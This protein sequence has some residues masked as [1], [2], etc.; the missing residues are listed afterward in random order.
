[1]LNEIANGDQPALTSMSEEEEEEEEGAAY[2]RPPPNQKY[3]QKRSS[4][5]TLMMTPT[6]QTS[7][8]FKSSKLRVMKE[9]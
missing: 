9:Y 3:E 6:V 5:G 1:M 2:R 4:E 8:K 7:P